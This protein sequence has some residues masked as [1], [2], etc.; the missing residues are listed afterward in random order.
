MCAGKDNDKVRGLM[1]VT[2]NVE[3]MQ[4][5]GF[6]KCSPYVSK[7]L[8]IVFG[9]GSEADILHYIEVLFEVLGSGRV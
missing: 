9:Q 3:R 7:L 5:Q 8:E 6:P 2:V 4:Y 1:C